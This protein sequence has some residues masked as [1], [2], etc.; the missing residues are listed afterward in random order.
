MKTNKEIEDRIKILEHIYEFS[1]NLSELKTKIPPED[2][3]AVE[4]HGD[5]LFL[6]LGYNP[7]IVEIL[8][9]ILTKTIDQRVQEFNQAIEKKKLLSEYMKSHNLAAINQLNPNLMMNIIYSYCWVFDLSA[10]TL[11]EYSI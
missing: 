2:Y 5:E 10:D 1:H 11:E 9:K 4:M 3:K 6:V 7:S 8:N